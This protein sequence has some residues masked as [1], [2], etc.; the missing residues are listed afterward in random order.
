MSIGDDGTYFVYSIDYEAIKKLGRNEK[1]SD[2]L[3]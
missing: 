2:P 1:A 3:F